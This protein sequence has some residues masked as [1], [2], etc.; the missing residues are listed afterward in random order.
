LLNKRYPQGDPSGF[1]GR[2]VVHGHDN[3]LEGPL[4]YEGR[5]NLDTLAWR[6]E[7]LVIG[8]FDDAKAGGPVAFIEV[9]GA[10][11]GF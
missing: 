3:F 10:P 9:K 8:V 6:T 7:W 5:S 4:L 11:A 2:H 1:G